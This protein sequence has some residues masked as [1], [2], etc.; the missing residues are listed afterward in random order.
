M[1]EDTHELVAQLCTKI[2]MIME[3]TA[4]VALAAGSLEPIERRGALTKLRSAALLIQA[5]S[6]TAMLLDDAQM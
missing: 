6:A 1:D 4:I 2:G 5:L 3:D